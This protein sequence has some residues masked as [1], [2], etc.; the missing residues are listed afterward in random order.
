M[1]HPFIFAALVTAALLLGGSLSHAGE[2]KATVAREASGADSAKSAPDAKHKTAAKLEPA[3]PKRVDINGASK[4]ELKKLPGI[5]DAE[6][7]RI[8]AGRPYG[9]KS[10]LVSDKVISNDLFGRISSLIE[11]KQPPFKSLA[12]LKAYYSKRKHY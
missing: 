1:K 2:S 5:G 8:I 10:W 11:A 4:E 6:A 9:S 12:E 3:K 7:D